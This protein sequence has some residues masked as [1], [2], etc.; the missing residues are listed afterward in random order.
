[1]A[2]ALAD[3]LDHPVWTG[4]LYRA[5]CWVLRFVGQRLTTTTQTT[6]NSIYLQLELNGLARHRE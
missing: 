1:M 5:G 4:R 6:S 2:K 3:R